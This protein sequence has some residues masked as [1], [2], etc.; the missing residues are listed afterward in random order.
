MLKQTL[1]NSQFYG[2]IATLTSGSNKFYA[3]AQCSSIYEFKYNPNIKYTLYEALSPV[4]LIC[5]IFWRDIKEAKAH[6]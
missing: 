4:P 3:C 5:P 1:M 2:Q 6:S